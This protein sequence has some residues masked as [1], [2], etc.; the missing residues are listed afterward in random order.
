MFFFY[1]KETIFVTFYVSEFVKSLNST[2]E[3]CWD[4]FESNWLIPDVQDQVTIK[5]PD[6]SSKDCHVKNLHDQVNDCPDG[7]IG[8]A[9]EQLCLRIHME[10]MTN[11]ESAFKCHEDGSDLFLPMNSEEDEYATDVLNKYSQPIYP[12]HFHIGLYQHQEAQEYYQSSGA[13]V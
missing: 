5:L 6:G 8:K 7:F 11:P 1:H 12:G 9:D 3:T 4:A 13:R 2:M 10:P